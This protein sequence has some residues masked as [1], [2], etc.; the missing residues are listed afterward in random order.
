MSLLFPVHRPSAG[1]SITARRVSLVGIRRG[2]RKTKLAGVHER[3]LPDGLLTASSSEPTIHD[4]QAFATELRAMVNSARDRTVA[5]CLPD[6]VCHLTLF[7]FET[8]PARERDREAILRWR[9][10]HDE[11]VAVGD[12]R[13]WHRVFPLVTDR[14]ATPTRSVEE[15]PVTAYVLALAIK[16]SIVTQYEA[17]C[18]Q[19]GILPVSITCA[20]L[21]LFDFYRPVMRPA[22]ALFFVHLSSDAMTLFA[23]KDGVPVY[24][25][26]KARR[27]L[28]TAMPD[29]VSTV[30]FYHDLYPQTEPPA[31]ETV[32]LYI[33]GS[34]VQRCEEA[35]DGSATFI[36]DGES[37]SASCGGAVELIFPDWRTLVASGAAT[38]ET[39]SGL[40]ALAS[41]VSA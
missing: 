5:L 29:I 39:D 13:L 28:G 30:Q 3:A 11:H 17:A 34:G 22:S 25:R 4:V 21:S 9:F 6:R 18:Q 1:L 14:E 37:A 23:V 27:G 8:L 36:S 31:E 41:A 33:A 20:A 15:R 16:D 24:C 32:P 10:Q 38:L 12:A 7:P 40:S 2:W 26:T 35:G 19:A